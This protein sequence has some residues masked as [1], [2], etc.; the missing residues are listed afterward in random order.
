M[1]N[2]SK[3]YN[4]TVN[5]EDLENWEWWKKNISNPV[6]NAV[7]KAGDALKNVGESIKWAPLL[8]FK[9]AMVNALQR[10]GYTNISRSNSIR[11]IS[12]KF[13]SV[14]IKKNSNYLNL[15]HQEDAI[16]LIVKEIIA[17]IKAISDK[18]KSGQRLSQGESD[19]VN[20]SEGAAE[21]IYK[22]YQS[23]GTVS[24]DT[25]IN[26]GKQIISGATSGKDIPKITQPKPETQTNVVSAGTPKGGAAAPE[27]WFQKNKGLLIGVAAVVLILII[28]KRK[29]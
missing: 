26:A 17:F 27:N 10:K 11:E 20:D 21:K 1:D 6:K 3:S 7:N 13:Y 28:A 18:K 16:S 29:K 8:P 2:S 9:G 4:A 19:F 12:E 22:E 23:T 14:I 25:L 15:E 24:V 5:I